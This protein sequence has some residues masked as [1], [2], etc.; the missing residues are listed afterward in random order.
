MDILLQETAL[1]DYSD[2]TIASLIS[3]KGWR[4]LGNFERLNQI[5]LFVRDEI[6]F[7]YNREDRIPA[8]SVL[9]DGYGQC[10]TKSTL[11]MAL[12]RAVGIPCR[13]HGFLI[14]KALQKGAMIG[15]VYRNAP[16]HI[17][18][19]WV[20]ACLDG[21]WYDLEGIILD[22]SYL[23]GLHRKFPERKGSFTGY[24]VAVKDFQHPE[25][26]FSRNDT[27]IQKEGI[28][29][30]LGTFDSPD[31]LF[32]RYHQDLTPVRS[33]LYQNLGRHLMNRNIRKIRS[34]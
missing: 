29:E 18:H 26:D 30:D 8:S 1:L 15:I 27:Y 21:T 3:K 24:G 32:A 5:Y 20:E 7:G 19:S 6:L 13:M 14:N 22:R 11:F 10:N 4:T 23:E 17:L 2:K 28:T 31:E 33:F 34:T 25:I 16:D 9:W 12:L